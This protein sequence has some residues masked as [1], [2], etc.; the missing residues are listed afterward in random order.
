MRSRLVCGLASVTGG[1]LVLT[2]GADPATC[3]QGTAHARKVRAQ[4]GR[5]F[6]LGGHRKEQAFAEKAGAFGTGGKGTRSKSLAGGP[7]RRWRAS[8]PVDVAISGGEKRP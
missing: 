7:R 5:L 2:P 8:S 4:W 6:R 3:W 1:R